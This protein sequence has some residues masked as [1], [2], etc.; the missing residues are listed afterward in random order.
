MEAHRDMQLC[1][2]IPGA[3]ELCNHSLRTSLI[4][5]LR[6]NPVAIP[7]AAAPQ[8]KGL[9]DRAEVGGG[10]RF[11]SVT[12]WT[13]TQKRT[14][15]APVWPRDAGDYRAS[16]QQAEELIE[17]KQIPLICLRVKGQCK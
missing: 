12:S 15:V 5:F 13:L 6:C 7:G 10:F 16:A 17:A 4:F 3:R 11:P 14:H 2:G 9:G 1:K 8:E